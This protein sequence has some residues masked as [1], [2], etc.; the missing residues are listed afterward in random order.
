MSTINLWF[1]TEM[2]EKIASGVGNPIS[3]ITK[4]VELKNCLHFRGNIDIFKCNFLS[5]FWVEL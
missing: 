4:S 1:H 5:H 3:S 2:N